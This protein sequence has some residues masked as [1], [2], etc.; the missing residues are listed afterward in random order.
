MSDIL[1][2]AAVWDDDAARGWNSR[3]GGAWQCEAERWRGA[4]NCQICRPRCVLHDKQHGP[5]GVRVSYCRQQK[6][7]NN[8]STANWTFK[9]CVE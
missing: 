8:V 6:Y 4:W 7:Y 3:Q 9:T 1:F 2:T 5:E